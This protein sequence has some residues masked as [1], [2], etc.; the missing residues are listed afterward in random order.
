ML[1]FR[2]LLLLI[3]HQFVYL[4]G[5]TLPCAE[6]YICTGGSNTPTPTNNTMG[7]ICPVGYYCLEG[8][9]TPR[10]C[11]PG[12][13]SPQTGLGE[14]THTHTHTHIHIYY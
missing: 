2:L 8:D 7:Y 1:W 11:V 13:Y 3:F 9:I 10:P 4:P 5:V 12:T 6:G 14:H